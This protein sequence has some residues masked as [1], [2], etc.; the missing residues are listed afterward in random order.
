MGGFGECVCD[1]CDCEQVGQMDMN[2]HTP[3]CAFRLPQ[4]LM[5]RERYLFPLWHLILTT[6]SPTSSSSAPSNPVFP[7]NPTQ[8]PRVFSCKWLP[9][10][11]SNDFNRPQSDAGVMNLWMRDRETRQTEQEKEYI[12][13][14]GAA[15]QHKGGYMEHRSLAQLPPELHGNLTPSS[16]AGRGE[17]ERCGGSSRLDLLA[18]C[19]DIC[20]WR[21]SSPH[22]VI[23][24]SVSNSSL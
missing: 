13:F 16:I 17:W 8:P 2:A 23:W 15:E 4:L 24:Q 7:L 11:T 10:T 18:V 21:I 14:G 5:T 20:N 1:C 6:P 22:R 12:F 3:V 19:C 9:L